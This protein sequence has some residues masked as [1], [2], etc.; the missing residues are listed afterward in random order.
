MQINK[1]FEHPPYEVEK[2][3]RRLGASLKTARLRRNLTMKEVAEKIGTGTRAISDAEN[4]KI[5]TSIGVYAALLWAMGILEQLG[6]VA[7]PTKDIE[8]QT[9]ASLKERN[10]ARHPGDLDNDF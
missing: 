2:V 5:T 6:E 9:L 8:G 10:R 3:L 1:L 7:E 4:G